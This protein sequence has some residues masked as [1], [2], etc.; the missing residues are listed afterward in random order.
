MRSRYTTLIACPVA[1]MVLGVACG[2]D[3]PY[4]V[5]PGWPGEFPGGWNPPLPWPS[6]AVDLLMVAHSALSLVASIS[7]CWTERGWRSRLLDFVGIGVLWIVAGA[8]WL[9][10]SMATTGVYL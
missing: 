6:R 4:W 8:C 5:E 2:R 10:A 7:L 9:G 3:R 1:I